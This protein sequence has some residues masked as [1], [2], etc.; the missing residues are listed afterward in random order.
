[1][2]LAAPAAAPLGAAATAAREVRF[3][4]RDLGQR[5][6]M[7]LR[8]TQDLQGVLFGVRGDEVV[9]EARLVLSGAVSAAL[10][11]S[12]SQLAITLNEQPV[13]QITPDAAR[14]SFGPLEFPIDPIAFTDLN[15]LNFRF[16]GRYTAEC[17]DPLSGL[18][19]ATVSDLST[20]S[21]RIERLPPQRDLARLPEPLFDARD[22]RS[23][24]NLPV[25]LAD[26][27]GA[28]AL[29]AAAIASSWFAV[30]AGYRGARFPVERALPA[31]GDAVVIAAGPDAVPGLILPRLEGPTLAVLP[32]P[33]DPF[34]TLLV[35]AGRTEAEAAQAATV[36]ALGR[37]GLSGPLATVAPVT[38][39]AR[40]PY[41]A[42]LWLPMGQEVRLGQ[43][44]DRNTLQA[45]GFQTATIRVPL[46]TAPDLYTWRGRG[47][48]LDLRWRA[49]PGPVVDVAVSR[50]D[51]G[52]SD[53]FLRA[54]P[55]GQPERNWMVE[56]AMQ[57]LWPRPDT[58][59]GRVNLPTYLLLGRGELEMRFDMRPLNRGDCAAVPA[60]IRAS[61]DPESALDLSGV[62]RYARLPNL[63]FFATAGFPFTRM[64]DLSGTAAVVPDRPNP[65][66]TQAFLELIGAL[67]AIVG[68]PATGLQVVGP[69]G[70][71][72]VANRDL[73][74]IGPLGRQPAI[75]QLLADTPVSLQ[76]NR[77]AVSLPGVLDE[78][79]AW[80]SDAP[81]PAER[82]RASAHLAE[83]GEGMAALIGAESRLQSGK[84][85]VV[86][87]G[88]T[89]AA[90]AELVTALR[91]PAQVPRFQ[92]D[93]SVLS[94]GRIAAFRT[95]PPYE[96]GELPWWLRPQALVEGRFER[97]AILMLMAAAMLGLPFYWMLRRRAALRLRG[98]TPKE[99]PPH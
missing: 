63:A 41:D 10:V 49:P 26:G 23:E 55:L 5:G 70:V 21:L 71:A 52:I 86:L 48:P 38:P 91:D 89:P 60:D 76:G 95:Q 40:D 73:L 81:P 65:V 34:G 16:T 54:F 84:S 58:R 50:L 96:V 37:T 29:R 15:R 61:I 56:W 69:Q 9:T 19:W 98:R 2:G 51:V 7:Q 85:V 72:G 13:G 59:A 46:R 1:P 27:A 28:P 90:M 75:Q 97:V 33:S 53:T 47:L 94:G 93:V 64:A 99:G 44:V 66:E 24:L 6:P 87:T 32:N 20:L 3:T 25:V 79:R 31:R 17:N 92:G 4:L 36:L 80:L 83:M 35:I 30:R 68:V 8:G 12:L 42:P 74:V 14:Q 18:L 78:A 62:H 82:V 22:L 45:A 57:R 88:A 43:L 77:L 39:P 11:P 67:S